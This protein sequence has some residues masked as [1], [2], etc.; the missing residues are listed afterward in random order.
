MQ[1]RK[2]SLPETKNSIEA[3]RD[4]YPNLCDTDAMLQLTRIILPLDGIQ[5]LT[6]TL[7]TL[8]LKFTVYVFR[9]LSV[10]CG[11]CA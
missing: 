7:Y 5:Y 8:L 4:S 10:K 6:Y 11:L 3:G 2:E 9:T 1:L